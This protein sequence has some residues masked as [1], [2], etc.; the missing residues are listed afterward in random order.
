[1]KYSKQEVMLKEMS[2]E[3]RIDTYQRD[4]K[5]LDS[6]REKI[7]KGVV[8]NGEDIDSINQEIREL[9]DTVTQYLQK[10]RQLNRT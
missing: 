7:L 5:A 2:V 4:V 8:F 3:D 10:H 1:M 9:D 6:K